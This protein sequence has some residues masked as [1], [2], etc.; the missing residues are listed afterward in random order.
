M[1]SVAFNVVS[2]AA[3]AVRNRHP[4][5]L[6]ISRFMPALCH[7]RFASGVVFVNTHDSIVALRAI[8]PGLLSV[9]RATMLT[10]LH[11]VRK[12]EPLPDRIAVKVAVKVHPFTAVVRPRLPA[13]RFSHAGGDKI[14]LK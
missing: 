4:R 11:N 2:F 5:P 3:L 1:M 14:V 8:E 7:D 6:C 13:I 12:I 9:V 10:V